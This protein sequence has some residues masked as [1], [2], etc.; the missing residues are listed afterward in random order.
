MTILFVRHGEGYH[1]TPK[2]LEYL[3]KHGPDPVLT[4]RGIRQARALG[5]YL[6]R[7]KHP[8]M[9][10]P[11]HRGLK[12]DRLYASPMKRCLQTAI[13]LRGRSGT[14]IHLEPDLHECGGLDWRT[15]DGELFSTSGVTRQELEALAPSIEPH[16][17]ITEEGWWFS[18]EETR[19]EWEAR[20]ERVVTWLETLAESQL[21][22]V[23]LVTHAG[24]ADVVLRRIFG[25]LDGAGQFFR[26]N[27]AALTRVEIKPETRRRILHFHNS[28]SHLPT[29]LLT[30]W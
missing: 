25:G 29:R 27:N 30:E 28:V 6:R 4:S 17:R 1:N 11:G 18:S 16:E 14:R 24:I 12:F 3:R 23:L 22:S 10:W 13:H 19:D 7:H 26:M 21:E 8:S 20:G 5:S 9:G 15:P 2:A